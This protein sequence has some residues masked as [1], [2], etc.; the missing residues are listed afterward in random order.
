MIINYRPELLPGEKELPLAKYYELPLYSP[1]PL[2]QQIL[3]S[4]PMD[5]ELAIKAENWLDLLKLV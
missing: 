3:D 5:P 1:A 2:Q 4:G